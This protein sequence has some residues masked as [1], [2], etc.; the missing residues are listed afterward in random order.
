VAQIDPHSGVPLRHSRH[1]TGAEKLTAYQLALAS[2]AS[3][4][5]PELLTDDQ[6]ASLFGVPVR[7]FT[8]K[9]RHEPWMP[10]PRMLSP[11]TRRWP[12]TDLLNAIGSIP[13]QTL[14]KSPP[15]M[16]VL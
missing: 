14:R 3:I 8:E 4:V 15:T 1:V 13:Q 7:T 11:R 10:K 16:T 9:L 12:R 5:E 2:A 6:A